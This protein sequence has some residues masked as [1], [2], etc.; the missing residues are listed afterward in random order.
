MKEKIGSGCYIMA[1]ILRTIC[2][3]MKLKKQ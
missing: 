1:N 3:N 2:C